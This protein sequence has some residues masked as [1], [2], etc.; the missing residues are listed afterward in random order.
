MLKKF[1]LTFAFMGVI[2]TGF[3]QN[4]DFGLTGGFANIA[5]R[6]KEGNTT[7]SNSESGIYVGAFADFEVNSGFSIQPELL[8]VT[9]EEFQ[10][11]VVPISAKFYMTDIFNIQVGPQ[12]AFIL[13]EIPDSFTGVQIDIAGGI[14]LDIT[15]LFFVQ[16]RYSY[17]L[18]NTFTGSDDVKIKYNYLTIGVGYKFW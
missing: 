13:E 11:L 8:Y 17:Q 3:A 5:E 14:G 10:S 18:N 1:L 16:A 7:I 6:I 2:F 4:V 9:V 15:E 12:L